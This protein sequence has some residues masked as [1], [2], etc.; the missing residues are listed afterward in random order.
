MHVSYS[1]F[2]N[3]TLSQIT[4]DEY[5]RIA[6][7]ADA[8]IDHWTHGRVGRAVSAGDALPAS[9]K[10]LYCAIVESMPAMAA[11]SKV[12]EGGVL[13]SFSNGVDSYS[14]ASDESLESRLWAQLGWMVDVLPV[15]WIS[16]AA[17]FDGGVKYAG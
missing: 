13:T 5:G 9:V 11:A 7:M 10:A 4:L 16:A 6:P 1:D 14:F 17:Y 3:L 2:T 8:V 15:E 12:S